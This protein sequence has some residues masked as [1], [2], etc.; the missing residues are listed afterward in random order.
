[1]SRYFKNFNTSSILGY[2]SSKEFKNV[3]NLSISSLIFQCQFKSW[4]E[5]GDKEQHLR[6]K[7]TQKEYPCSAYVQQSA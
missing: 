6:E 1:M 3:G 5:M 7:V 2:N 4:S